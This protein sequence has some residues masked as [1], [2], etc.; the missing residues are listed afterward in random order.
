MSDLV[1][2]LQRKN[3][4]SDIELDPFFRKLIILLQSDEISAYDGDGVM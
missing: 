3:K 4:L 2:D 1:H